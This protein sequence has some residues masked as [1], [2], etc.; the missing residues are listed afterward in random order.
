MDVSVIDRNPQESTREY[1]YRFLKF[2]IM[3]LKLIPGSALSEKDIALLLGVSRTPVREAFIQLSQEYLLDILPQKGTY[4]SLIDIENVEESKFLR[5]TVEK[6]VI[7]IA[8]VQF[9]SDKLFELQSNI[10]LQELCIKEKNYLK[11]YELDEAMHRTIF[12]GCKKT[13]IW[14]MI[15]QMNTHY[16]RVRILNIAGGYDVPPVL[17]QHQELVQAIKEKDVDLGVKTIHRHLNKVKFDIQDLYRDY[18]G[19]FK[20]TQATL[21]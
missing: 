10:A 3:E 12:V 13:R 5:E 1:V 19:Y 17:K 9:P 20:Q 8:C 14:S 11:F 2:N 6:A 4:V 16:N 21:R 15:Q 18:V 7:E